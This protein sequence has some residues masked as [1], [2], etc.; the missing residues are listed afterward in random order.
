[1]REVLARVEVFEDGGGGGEVF[2]GE[3]YVGGGV[4]GGDGGGEEG[5]VLEE[6]LV[7]AEGGWGS[8]WADGEGYN[9]GFEVA[10]TRS[11]S[12]RLSI[13]V[14][15]GEKSMGNYVLNECEAWFLRGFLDGVVLV[16][17]R[18]ICSGCLFQFC[19]VASHFDILRF[20][21]LDAYAD[22]W[23]GHCNWR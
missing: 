4:G 1:M 5:G 15:G 21:G 17:G 12:W 13:G 11:I 20:F 9:G 18:F 7:G 14:M 22:L 10:V 23:L 8:G 6:E 16:A 19:A 3:G 2:V